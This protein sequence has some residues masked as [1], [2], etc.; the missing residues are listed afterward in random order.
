MESH[1]CTR[2]NKCGNKH[3]TKGWIADVV[4]DKLKS[5]G[6]VSCSELKKWLMKTYNV[7]VPYMRV[8]KGKELAYADMYGNWEGSFIKIND[9]KEE[10]R[11]RNAGSV[12]EIDFETKGNKKTFSTH[13]YIISRLF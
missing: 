10:L 4:T 2:S 8:S 11:K 13:F 3:A 5:D 9:F 1:S 7:D 12:V 6:D